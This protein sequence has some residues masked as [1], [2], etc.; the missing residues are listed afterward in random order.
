MAG[1]EDL[2][3][4]FCIINEEFNPFPFSADNTGQKS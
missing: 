2:D 4:E 3:V 1:S